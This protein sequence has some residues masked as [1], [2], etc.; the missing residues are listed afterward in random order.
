MQAERK[1]EEN[2][3]S[4]ETRRG[5]KKVST[6]NSWMLVVMICMTGERHLCH[7]NRWRLRL[8]LQRCKDCRSAWNPM[9][10]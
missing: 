1:S 3:H 6:G 5:E 7:L 10:L 4:D 8:L 9:S 2:V